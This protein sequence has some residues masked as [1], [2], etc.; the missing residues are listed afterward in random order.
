MIRNYFEHN[1]LQP[2]D[3]ECIPPLS[4]PLATTIRIALDARK[5][6]LSAERVEELMLQAGAGVEVE[7]HARP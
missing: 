4:D 3:R 2:L 1:A 7:E 6:G 5:L